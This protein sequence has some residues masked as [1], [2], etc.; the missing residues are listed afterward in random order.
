MMESYIADMNHDNNNNDDDDDEGNSNNSSKVPI[1]ILGDCNYRN[2]DNNRS[3]IDIDDDI[4]SSATIVGDLNA[5]ATYNKFIIGNGRNLDDEISSNSSSNSGVKIM[6]LFHA[7]P[8]N[9][10]NEAETFRCNS[11]RKTCDMKIQSDCIDSYDNSYS[12]EN[13][14]STALFDSFG[15]SYDNSKTS[16]ENINSTPHR[17]CALLDDLYNNTYIHKNSY[18]QNNSSNCYSHRYLFPPYQQI[19]SSDN[20]SSSSG[21]DNMNIT[22]LSTSTGN[23]TIRSFYVYSIISEEQVDSLNIKMKEQQLKKQQLEEQQKQLLSTAAATAVTVAHSWKEKKK[24][25]QQR[26]TDTAVQNDDS[27]SDNNINSAKNF[28]SSSSMAA[29]AYL[30]RFELSISS[31]TVDYSCLN[32][33][34]PSSVLTNANTTY[35]PATVN[36]TE[37]Q[38]PPSPP[39]QQQHRYNNYIIDSFSLSPVTIA[40]NVKNSRLTLLQCCSEVGS[41]SV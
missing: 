40:M 34:L 18:E 24:Q 19:S 28:T 8:A 3:T 22:P 20:N 2:D 10:C 25:Q 15:L 7:L 41:S 27:K 32:N 33:S 14:S 1:T 38:P 12:K 17:F 26:T 9:I 13:S 36:T 6:Q 29:V 30:N 16:S 35:V 5:K 21:G 11:S 39:L 31:C 23:T 4:S 37:Y